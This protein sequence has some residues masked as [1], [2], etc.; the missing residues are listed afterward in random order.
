MVVTL[1]EVKVRKKQEL[2]LDGNYHMIM[3]SGLPLVKTNQVTWLD[4]LL[5]LIMCCWS[6][7]VMRV[8]IMAKH[9]MKRKKLLI[10]YFWHFGD[11]RGEMLGN[12]ARYDYNNSQR[13]LYLSQFITYSHLLDDHT[14]ALHTNRI[15]LSPFTKDFRVWGAPIET[16]PIYLRVTYG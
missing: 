5:F 10:I 14:Q 16:Y 6:C 2:P 8:A 15:N 12:H 9:A 7:V 11:S 13:H 4:L 1:Y 3:G